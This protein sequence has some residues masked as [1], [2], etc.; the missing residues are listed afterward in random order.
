MHIRRHTH[1]HNTHAYNYINLGN[2]VTYLTI[3]MFNKTSCNFGYTVQSYVHIIFCYLAMYL[4]ND[5]AMMWMYIDNF[6]DLLQ[7][8]N[9][10]IR[11][12]FVKLF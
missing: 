1:A 3:V 2:F 10:Y 7:Y 11:M 8:Y 12:Y 5:V 9:N 6:S 4:C